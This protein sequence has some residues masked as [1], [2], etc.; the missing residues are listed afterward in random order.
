MSK[1]NLE[2]FK[3]IIKELT[4]EAKVLGNPYIFLTE[5]DR[6]L[7]NKGIN[8]YRY[9]GELDKKE[10]RIIDREII[11]QLIKCSNE[12][13]ERFDAETVLDER[14]K[15]ER[16]FLKILRMFAKLKDIDSAYYLM[17]DF[18]YYFNPYDFNYILILNELRTLNLD[19]ETEMV[20][21]RVKDIINID[22]DQKFTER[23]D[24]VQD[25]E[26]EEVSIREYLER[27]CKEEPK[28]E[29]PQ[30]ECEEEEYPLDPIIQAIEELFANK[31]DVKPTLEMAKEYLK[32]KGLS[33][34][35]FSK[36]ELIE[37]L[38]V[39]A[40]LIADRMLFDDEELAKIYDSMWLED[41]SIYCL[42]N[43]SPK[44]PYCKV[45]YLFYLDIIG[46]YGAEQASLE[47]YEF[48]KKRIEP[49][50]VEKLL[51]K[52]LEDELSKRQ[53]RAKIKPKQKRG[54]KD[55]GIQNP[56]QF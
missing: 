39:L 11:S 5:L 8:L 35:T 47:A 3:Q 1:V 16:E 50:E 20:E 56:S 46:R 15:L 28:V 21:L 26:I 14:K 29:L 36:R 41:I 52:L 25:K 55:E 44:N 31:A 23:E 37:F 30:C 32:T 22:E 54:V 17:H 43:L 2:E 45:M 53:R 48:V 27:R 34:E 51:M 24:V 9:T 49:N 38:N 40:S 10:R 6:L 4:D 33:L 42:K 13:L 7:R 19:P 18:Y 12:I